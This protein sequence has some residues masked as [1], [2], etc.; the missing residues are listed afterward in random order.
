MQQRSSAC[1][2]SRSVVKVEYPTVFRRVRSV[3]D[4][5]SCSVY[6]HQHVVRHASSWQRSVVRAE[7]STGQ[8]GSS[9]STAK[10]VR[11]FGM[12]AL[13]AG[14]KQTTP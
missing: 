1:C 2:S 12:K 10:N 8:R 4:V 14:T 13:L 6:A 7:S 11:L 9:R 5:S 3:E